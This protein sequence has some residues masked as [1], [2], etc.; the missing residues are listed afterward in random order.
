LEE[1]MAIIYKVTVSPAEKE[2]EKENRFRI[3]WHNEEKE[4]HDYFIEEST[5]TPEETQ[6]LWHQPRHQL[7]IGRKLFRFLDGDSRY[8]QRPW[9]K[10]VSK[11]NHFTSTLVRKPHSNTKSLAKWLT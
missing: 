3:T 4:L 7:E 11:A 2:A 9:T 8:L 6:V 10:R 1:E 5:L